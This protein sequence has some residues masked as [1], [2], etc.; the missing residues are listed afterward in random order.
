MNDGNWLPQPLPELSDQTAAEILDFLQ[1]FTDAFENAY[2]NQIRRHYKNLKSDRNSD[3][4]TDTTYGT[5]DP[6]F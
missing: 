3:H 4:H 2:A 1:I 5:D 6:P